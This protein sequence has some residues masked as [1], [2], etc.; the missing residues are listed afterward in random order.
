MCHVGK[1]ESLTLVAAIFHQPA[2]DANDILED[3]LG[4]VLQGHVLLGL[5]IIVTT[6]QI[7]DEHG[8][9]DLTVP[10]HQAAKF[11]LQGLLPALKEQ[12]LQRQQKEAGACRFSVL[13]VLAFPCLCQRCLLNSGP[14]PF[15]AL[16]SFFFERESCSVTRLECSD[17]ILAH[18]NLRLPGSSN[19]PASAS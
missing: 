7:Q 15:S 6:D 18:C 12:F 14:L 2:G 19:S 9:D 1:P 11:G 4:Q 13:P 17:T 10:R 8:R 5:Q 16:I 3:A